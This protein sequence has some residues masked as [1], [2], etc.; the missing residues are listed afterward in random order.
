MAKKLPPMHPGEVLR[1]EFLIPLD[2]S[3]GALAKACGVP[4]TRIERIASEETSITA[5]TALR[6][7]KAL[8]TSAQLWLNLQNAYDV[9][10]A[11]QEL[12][13]DLD[14]IKPIDVKAA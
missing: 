4:R 14:K 13:D 5:D 10:M 9:Q 6:L 11:E 2:I 1:E 7:S 12:G 3:A 8:K